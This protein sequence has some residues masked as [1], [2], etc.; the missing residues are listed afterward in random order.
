MFLVTSSS[1]SDTTFFTS[2]VPQ[3]QST[4]HLA[5]SPRKLDGL[6]AYELS[7]MANGPGMPKYPHLWRHRSVAQTA[8]ADSSTP[9]LVG[10]LDGLGENLGSQRGELVL[11][12]KCGSSMRTGECFDKPQPR[13]SL[14]HK[15]SSWVQ[16]SKLKSAKLG[17]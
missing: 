14:G 13:P 11:R 4:V 1:S 9:G 3:R 15:G 16:D 7:P 5:I 6:G 17:L 8:V 10:A 2:L 12:P